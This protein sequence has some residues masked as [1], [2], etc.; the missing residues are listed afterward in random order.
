MNRIYLTKDRRHLYLPLTLMTVMFTKRQPEMRNKA[1]NNRAITSLSF[2]CCI[3][4]SLSCVKTVIC[5]ISWS[6]DSS[7]SAT[8]LRSP[9]LSASS[10]SSRC[11]SDSCLLCTHYVATMQLVN[12]AMKGI[13]QWWPQ[14][15]IWPQQWSWWPQPQPRQ[16]ACVIQHCPREHL[17]HCW[18]LTCLFNDPS[19]M[20]I[21]I[22]CDMNHDSHKPWRPTWWNLSNDVKWG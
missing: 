19:E 20:Y 10:S 17:Q 12:A 9:S 7:S 21:M 6:R 1:Y 11:N 18:K 8:W 2:I 15:M 14:T 4:C 13:R 3:S 22:W 16:L 5:C